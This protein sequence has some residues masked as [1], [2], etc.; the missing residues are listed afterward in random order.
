MACN[1]HFTERASSRAT[2]P[3]GDEGVH[4]FQLRSSEEES[5]KSTAQNLPLSLGDAGC[6][7]STPDRRR[8]EASW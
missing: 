8:Q 2:S 1:E 5:S 3:Q 7:A 6:T 4:L